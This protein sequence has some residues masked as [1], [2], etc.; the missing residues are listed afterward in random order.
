MNSRYK[1][2]VTI[3]LSA[4][5][6]EPYFEIYVQVNLIGG[7]LNDSNRSSI[8]CIYKGETLGDKFDYLLNES[9]FKPWNLSSS[10]I[11]FDIDKMN[12]NSQKK[13]QKKNQLLKKNHN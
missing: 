11:Y 8:D 7:E 5:E 12:E 13:N 10:R 9:S 1:S 3:L 6:S 2:G 4:S